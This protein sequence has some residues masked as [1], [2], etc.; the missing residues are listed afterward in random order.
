[1][2]SVCGQHRDHEA[3]IETVLKDTQIHGHELAAMLLWSCCVTVTCVLLL[4]WELGL[5][6]LTRVRVH[7]EFP[8]LNFVIVSAPSTIRLH[9]SGGRASC[10]DGEKVKQ[11]ALSRHPLFHGERSVYAELKGAANGVA[12]YELGLRRRGLF[13][14]TD[15]AAQRSAEERNLQHFPD[16]DS[17]SRALAPA[18]LPAQRRMDQACLRRAAA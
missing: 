3:L 7:P 11:K 18:R 13:D 15:R 6:Y 5:V 14:R 1:M 16:R 10:R 2:N 4:L 12:L 9:G 17:S 8:E